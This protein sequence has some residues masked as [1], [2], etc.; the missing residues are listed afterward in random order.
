VLQASPGGAALPAEQTARLLQMYGVPV[1]PTVVT[2]SVDT[3]VAAAAK[4]GY[5]VA[6]KATAETLRHRPELG[7]VRLDIG[8]EDELR[9]AYQAMTARLGGARAGLAV[10]AMAPQGVATVVRTAEDPSFGALISFGVGGV[11]TDLLGDRSFRV[12]PL[13]DVDAAEL[14]RAVRAAPLLLGYRGTEPVDVAALEQLLLRVARLADDVPEVAALEL[15]PVLASP[16]GTFV[17][18]ATARVA[19]PASRLDA[20]P[21]RLR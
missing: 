11:A 4:V 3:A 13:T 5:P 2:E 9:A 14:V 15:N 19:V 7:T 12:L 17:L 10:Q 18:G 8:S 6:L 21:R 1:W 16:H 20:G